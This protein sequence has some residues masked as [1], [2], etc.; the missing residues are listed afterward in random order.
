MT[1]LD[2][3]NKEI[4]NTYHSQKNKD[5]LP[6]FIFFSVIVIIFKNA[7]FYE[8]IIWLIYYKY[9]C[10]NNEELNNNPDNLKHRMHLLSIRQKLLNGECNFFKDNL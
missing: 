10:K 4:H 1:G 9:C 6:I 7:L 8:I 5:I 3:I 2:R